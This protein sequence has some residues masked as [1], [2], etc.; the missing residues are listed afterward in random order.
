[1]LPQ[2]GLFGVVVAIGLLASSRLALIGRGP[3]SAFAIRTLDAPMSVGFIVLFSLTLISRVLAPTVRARAFPR[4]VVT[5]ASAAT[6]A[7][8]RRR[9]AHVATRAAASLDAESAGRAVA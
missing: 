7:R 2:R 6:R 9:S 8:L 1:M 5:Q 3:R 4:G